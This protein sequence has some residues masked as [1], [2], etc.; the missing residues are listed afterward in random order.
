[1]TLFYYQPKFLEHDTGSHPENA[2]RL[3]GVMKRLESENI[4]DACSCPQWQP[5]TDD[6][7]RYAHEQAD[8]DAIRNFIRRGGG[9]IEADTVVSPSSLDPALLAAGAACDA[10][11]RVVRGDATNAFCLV[12]PPGHHAL[13]DNPM[14]FCLF[15]NVAIAA[16]AAIK[17]HGLERVLILD[18]D[19]HHGNGTQAIFW[20]DASVAFLSMHRYP[21][22]PG[23]GG[24]DETGQGDGLGWTVNLPI[25]FGTPPA[26]Q[27][28]RFRQATEKL[29]AKLRPQLVLI[30][31]GFDSHIDDPIGSL[32]LES[33]HF[34]TL[35]EVA[36]SVARAHAD[37]RIV[38]VLEGG[39][40][41]TALG[42]SVLFHLQT[43]M[44]Q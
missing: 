22:Y 23:T 6:Q 20:E 31:A 12:R 9:L 44:R 38:S 30:S 13:P 24:A 41:P 35:T 32:Q 17:E 27:I 18:W 15:N 39:Y 19:V 37:G 42:E 5:A 14:G 40:N 11:A 16:R 36:M 43:L 33:E 34:E 10:V 21:F 28:D 26:T 25:H 4:L 2:N 1:M 7:L 3:R 29:A 8:I